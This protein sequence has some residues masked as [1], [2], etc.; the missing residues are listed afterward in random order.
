MPGSDPA[1]ETVSN[2]SETPIELRPRVWSMA[3]VL[4]EIARR[5]RKPLVSDCYLMSWHR[6]RALGPATLPQIQSRI[7]RLWGVEWDL[8]D[9]YILGRSRTYF[10]RQAWDVPERLVT[11]WLDEIRNDPRLRLDTLARLAEWPESALT[12]LEFHPELQE[13]APDANG[14]PVYYNGPLRFYGLLSPAQRKRVHSEGLQLAYPELS[15]PM[16]RHFHRWLLEQAPHVPEAGLAEA[17]LRIAYSSEGHF[18]CHWKIGNTSS[19]SDSWLDIRR[20]WLTGEL[21]VREVDFPQRLAGKP[22]PAMTLRSPA[23]EP[24]LLPR[25]ARALRVLLIRSPWLMPSV[26]RGTGDEDLQKLSALLTA[27]PELAERI[28][29]IC[30]D[31]TPAE[32]KAWIAERKLALPCLADPDGSVRDV[33][34]GLREPRAIVVDEEKKVV[35][36]ISGYDQIRS[37]DWSTLFQ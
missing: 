7:D 25:D 10:A 27:R 29:L 13:T 23:G 8:Q 15:S 11:A 34:S 33:V 28:R 19:A 9:G 32:V 31:T 26:A 16:Q 5:T 37:V 24:V 36:I 18:Q 35:R 3:E 1:P 22:L 17:S 20:D 2:R 21:Q 12:A 6:V 30:P 14:F 4:S